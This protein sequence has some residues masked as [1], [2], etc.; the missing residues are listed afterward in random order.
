MKYNINHDHKFSAA[1]PCLGNQVYKE[2][3]D[4]PCMTREDKLCQAQRKIA[5]C[6]CPGTT[7][8]DEYVPIYDYL[9]HLILEFLKQFIF[10]I[11][12]YYIFYDYFIFIN[13]SDLLN[14]IKYLVRKDRYPSHF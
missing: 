9:F 3:D 6:Q 13:I 5:S 12:K 10:M 7:K 14:Y 1:P 11:I 2:V 4:K 8:W